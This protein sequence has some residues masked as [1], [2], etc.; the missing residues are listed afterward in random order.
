MAFSLIVAS[1]KLHP[2]FQAHTIMVM[3]NQPI[4][5]AMSKL[6]ATSRMIQWVSELSQF[7]IK[8]RLRTIIKAQALANFIA[9]FTFPNSNQEVEYWAIYTDGSSVSGL[10]SVS[11]IGTSPEKD[12]LRY[13]V[14]LQFPVMNNEV[15]YKAVLASLKIAKAIEVKNSKL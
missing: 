11:I 7:D 8:Y 3:M 6:D 4:Q 14:Q 2:Y 13:G 12:A 15:E 5:K 1:R 10:E 9:E